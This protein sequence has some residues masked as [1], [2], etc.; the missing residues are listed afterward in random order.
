MLNRYS[1]LISYSL[2]NRYSLLECYGMLNWY[3]LMDSNCLLNWNNFMN[4]N[5]FY[6]LNR[7]HFD[8]LN[9][10]HLNLLTHWGSLPIHR[11]ECSI[12]HWRFNFLNWVMRTNY[13]LLNWLNWLNWLN[14]WFYYLRLR[15]NNFNRR[16][17]WNFWQ[18]IKFI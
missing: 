2:L 1:L 6:L 11:L 17:S 14:R 5:H 3:L 12:N 13:W 4:R 9:W 7:D 16:L 18:N 10:D 8:L 15:R